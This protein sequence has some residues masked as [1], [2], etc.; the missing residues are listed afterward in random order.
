MTDKPIASTMENLLRFK[1]VMDRG[2]IKLGMMLNSRNDSGFYTLG[3]LIE[4]G[5]LGELVDITSLKPHKLNSAYR[6]QW[7]FDKAV[8][9]GLIIDLM[10]HDIDSL[11]WYTKDTFELFHAHLQKTSFPEYPEL[12]DLAQVT[13]TLSNGCLVTI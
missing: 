7:F 8:N 5:Q 12:Y 4:N 3:K 11:N 6:P 9:G 13:G 10:I 2:T 1:K